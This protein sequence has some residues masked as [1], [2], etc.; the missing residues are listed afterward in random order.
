MD[1][2]EIKKQFPI[3]MQ[4]IHEESFLYLDSA[5]TVPMPTVVQQQV[6]EFL[7][8][9]YANVHRGVYTTSQ[10]SS[11]RYEA[12]RQSVAQFLQAE[13]PESIVFT[14]GTT[15]SLNVIA[16]SFGE[17]FIQA[18]DEI[19]VS[20]LEHH[21]NLVPWQQLAKKKQATLRYL[22]LTE[23]LHVDVEK[24]K[25]MLTPRTKLIAIAYVSNVVGT[26]QPVNVL[27]EL[28]HD[29][30]G[31]IVVDGAQAVPHHRIDVKPFD[32]FA[33]SGHKIG[34]LTGVGVLYGKEKWLNQM[35]PI[36]HGGG[37]IATVE[38]FDST[39]TSGPEKFEAGTPN[40]VGVI[41]LGAAIDWLQA[42]GY[43]QIY[44]H[45]KRI[46]QYAYAQLTNIPGVR[47]YGKSDSGVIAF[48]VEGIHPHDV[49]TA[50]DFEGIAM[51]AGQHC[52]QVLLHH[53]NISATVRFSGYIYTS[54]AD[55]DRLV[56][57]IK[58]VK[59]F[60]NNGLN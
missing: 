51:R 25:A 17:Q 36:Q 14:S 4:Q 15:Q 16:Q 13:S 45:V 34:A 50:M 28:I 26:Q 30:G 55:V 2:C 8:T 58:R 19:F 21:A 54:T 56:V 24:T 52:A 49:A 33:F 9:D 10:R 53:L 18:G 42:I 40:I 43:Q 12:V 23:T 1:V 47:V 38:P 35:P 29:N 59:E 20:P 44:A 5:A 32:F 31:V 46:G 60:F 7:N 48:N 3:L 57:A 22:P 27:A 6:V 41:S 11:D 39:W 37:M